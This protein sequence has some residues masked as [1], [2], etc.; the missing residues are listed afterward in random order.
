M[1]QIDL[2]E[3]ELCWDDHRIWLNST[4]GNVLRLKCAGAVTVDENCR[5]SVPHADIFISGNVDLCVPT[6]QPV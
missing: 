2:G 1:K 5:N 4:G 3:C 6:P